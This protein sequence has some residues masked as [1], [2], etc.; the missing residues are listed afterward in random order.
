MRIFFDVINAHISL[1]IHPV[2]KR[3]NYQAHPPM[4]DVETVF[5]A[6]NL[7]IKDFLSRDNR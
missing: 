3:R 2:M 1:E 6:K 5:Y 4:L 7:I